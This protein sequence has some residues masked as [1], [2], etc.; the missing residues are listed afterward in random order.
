MKTLA[1]ALLPVLLLSGCA[2]KTGAEDAASSSAP[3]TA[4]SLSNLFVLPSDTAMTISWTASGAGWT[5]NLVGPNAGGPGVNSGPAIPATIAGASQSVTFTGLLPCASYSWYVAQN[6]GDVAQGQTNTRYS[7]FST[8]PATETITADEQYTFDGYDHQEDGA[9][10]CGDWNPAYAAWP[11][12]YGWRANTSTVGGS[13]GTVEFGFWHWDDPGSGAFACPESTV[14]VKRGELRYDLSASQWNRGVTNATLKATISVDGQ[15]CASNGAATPYVTTLGLQSWAAN[16]ETWQG[17]LWAPVMGGPETSVGLAT[18]QNASEYPLAVSGTTAT[19]NYGAPSA[20]TIYAGFAAPNDGFGQLA[21]G[22]VPS[23]AADNNN[24]MTTISN[25]TL[26]LSYAPM[27]PESPVN[28]TASAGCGTGAI[29]TCNQSPDTFRL[30]DITSN[31]VV[32]TASAASGFSMSDPAGSATDTYEVCGLGANGTTACSAPIAVTSVT[33]CPP[34]PVSVG[35]ATASALWTNTDGTATVTLNHAAP[36]GGTYVTMSCSANGSVLSLCPGSM[37]IPPG[38]TS[39]TFPIFTTITSAS[40]DETV[41]L[42]A[43]A[44]GTT[45]TSYVPYFSGNVGMIV[46]Y[47]NASSFV[48]FQNSGYISI[49]ARTGGGTAT[50]TQSNGALELYATSVAMSASGFGAVN[51]AATTVTEMTDTV[52]ASYEGSTGQVVVYVGD[53]PSGSGGGKFGGGGGGCKGTTCQ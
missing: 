33:L 48:E 14:H 8:C 41:T 34:V 47:G 12:G 11:V 42:T 25:A 46:V 32:G 49:Y 50:L 52:T 9:S 16:G 23:F 26:T 4:A 19:V 28:C 43:T 35:L 38:A 20:Q 40:V 2:V 3:V 21:N 13:Y 17:S 22:A 53:E 29:V 51:V 18:V 7:G 27:A 37:T 30:V 6:G 15:Q 45:V 36:A 44:D 5:V 1:V 39:A 10:Y 31:R 24:C